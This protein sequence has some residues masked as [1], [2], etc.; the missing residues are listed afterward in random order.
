MHKES[1]AEEIVINAVIEI[2][3][4][5]L[6]RLID[7]ELEMVEH[8]ELI[9]MRRRFGTKSSRSPF[10]PERVAYPGY[11]GHLTGK[12]SSRG[13]ELPQSSCNVVSIHLR[14]HV[15]VGLVTTANL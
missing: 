5:I 1:G 4:E 12:Q 10:Q 2:F 3:R 13:K 15:T 8:K 6:N 7:S 11:C 14:G 9:R